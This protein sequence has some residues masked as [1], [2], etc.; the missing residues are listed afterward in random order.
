MSNFSVANAVDVTDADAFVPEVWSMEILAAYKRRLVMA[1]LVSKL[2]HV[3]KKGDNI[4]IPRPARGDANEKT[5]Q[6]V[7][8]P[9]A[10]S[11]TNKQVSIDQHWEYSRLLEDKTELQALASLRRFLT[12]DAGYALATR[13]DT[14]LHN[15]AATWG[16]GTAYS[17]AVIGSDGTTGWSQAGSGNGAA[18]TDAAIRNVI[19]TLDDGNTPDEDRYLVIPPVAANTLMGISRFTEQAFIGDGSAIRTGRLGDI[20]GVEVYKS[21]NCATTEANDS[22]AYRVALMFQREALVLVEQLRVRTQTQYKL[23]A[24]ADLMV[25]DTLF[26]VDTVYGDQSAD[27]GTGCQAIVIPS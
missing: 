9:I 17:S 5:Q 1:N 6:V 12:N 10:F 3:G 25:S 2:N 13:T 27:A 4:N 15:L 16:N 21:T 26:G 7:V 8:T 11:D 19:Q 14:E 22:T 20:Y 24:L 23:E 18:L